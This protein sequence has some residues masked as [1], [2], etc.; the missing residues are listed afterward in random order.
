VEGVTNRAWVLQKI[1]YNSVDITIFNNS[2]ELFFFNIENCTWSHYR[3]S[4]EQLL[5]QLSLIRS[6][7]Y[8][9]EKINLTKVFK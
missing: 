3:I 6:T 9:I 4:I 8:K 1:Y 5:K 2:G 7:T